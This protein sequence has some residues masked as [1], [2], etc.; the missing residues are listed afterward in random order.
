MD[1]ARRRNGEGMVV[2]RRDGRVAGLPR[3]SDAE[4]WA[5]SNGCSQTASDAEL[6]NT[7]SHPAHAALGYHETAGCNQILWW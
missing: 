4:S 7:V 6:W 5:R 2:E 3:E 1:L